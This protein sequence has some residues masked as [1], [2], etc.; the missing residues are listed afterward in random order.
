MPFQPA[1]DVPQERRAYT[2]RPDAPNGTAV[3]ILHGFMGSPVSSRPMA[4]YLC[5]QGILVHCP[6]L[7]GH[8][9]Y[10][11]K[12]YNVPRQAW[13]AEVE[14]AYHL[15][16]RHSDRLFIIGHSM[17]NILGAHLIITYGGVEGHAM[18]APVYDLPDSRLRYVNLIRP[19]VPWFYPHKSQSKTLQKLMRER[20]LDFDPSLDFNDPHV[21]ARL[22]ELSRVP[23]SGMGE[24]VRMIHFGRRLWPQ[25][26]LPA[27]ILIGAEDRAASPEN[28][29]KIYELLAAEDK[30]FHLFPNTGHELMRPFEKAHTEVW[31]LISS[32]VMGQ[33]QLQPTATGNA[34]SEP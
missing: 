24:M 19:F 3:L 14:E 33:R 10:P 18:L 1:Y 17:G 31:K 11:N 21:Q 4:E 34:N 12:L 13:I 5:R 20:L 27:C 22:P 30:A 32:F 29:R 8:G 2:L 28:A 15:I 9:Q 6:L 26:T 23:F 25:L 16:R 7:P